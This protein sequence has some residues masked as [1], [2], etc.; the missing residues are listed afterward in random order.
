M[1]ETMWEKL[2]NDDMFWVWEKDRREAHQY[3]FATIKGWKEK[4][5]RWHIDPNTQ[6]AFY[7]RGRDDD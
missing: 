3:S 7:V 1:S 5:G 4:N 6:T 2:F